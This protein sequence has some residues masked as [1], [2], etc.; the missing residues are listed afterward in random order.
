MVGEGIGGDGGVD[1]VV[2]GGRGGGWRG[3]GGGVEGRE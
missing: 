1:I 2:G 3:S